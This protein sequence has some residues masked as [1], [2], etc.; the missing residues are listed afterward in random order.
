MLRAAGVEVA[1]RE[2]RTVAGV[3]GPPAREVGVGPVERLELGAVD[4]PGD[5]SS[6]AFFVVAAAL[7]PGSE[8][9][10]EAVGVNPTRVGLLGVLN[11]MGAAVSV[12]DEGLGPGGEPR[13]TVIA[14]HAPLEGTRVHAEEV[15]VTIDELPLV[16]LAGCFAEGE[17]IVE[18]AA[19][20]RH[21]ETDRIAGVV[22]GLAALGAEITATDDGFVVAGGGS[23]RGGAIDAR[24]DHRLAMLGAIAGLASDRGAE[25]G[26]SEAVAVSY[27]GFEADLRRLAG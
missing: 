14:R 27:P 8:V 11:R 4:V 21:K 17:T 19:E 25:V 23:L 10:I 18:G 16:A 7:V 22:D 2:L 5:F 12:E 3:G 6:A 15:A 26:G 20:L 1:T 24:G 9:R 13:G